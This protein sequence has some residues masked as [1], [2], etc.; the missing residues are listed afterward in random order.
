[1]AMRARQLRFLTALPFLAS[2][3]SLH[4]QGPDLVGNWHN[5]NDGNAPYLELSQIDPRY[6]IVAVNF[7]LPAHGTTY[8][9][10]PHSH[11]QA[12]ASGDARTTGTDPA[13][14]RTI[15]CTSRWPLSCPRS[16]T[17]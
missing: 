10:P 15:R 9:K 8:G 16:S 1:M 5:W 4:A 3:T 11:A 13:Y 6:S 14:Q 12:Q 7:A 17:K 2:F